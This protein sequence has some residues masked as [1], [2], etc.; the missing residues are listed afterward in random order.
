MFVDE[1][2]ITIAGGK[3]GDGM[4]HW[5][6]EKFVAKGGP[7]GGNGGRG[8][9]AYIEAVRNIRALER[10]TEGEVLCAGGGVQ[11]GGVLR[12]GRGGQ[13]IVVKVPVGSVV[14]NTYTLERFE[15]V[16]EGQRVLVA[17]G[18]KGGFGNA[19]FKSSVNTTPTV[20]TAGQEGQSYTFAIELHI[21]ADVGIIGFPNA[22]KSTLLNTLTNASARVA[23]YPFTTL[24]PNLGMFHVYTLADIPGLIENAS[25]GKGLGH[26][27]LRHIS[28]TK[29]LVH[30]ISAEEHDPLRAYQTI[31]DELSAYDQA[32]LKKKEIVVLSKVDM[33]SATVAEERLRMLPESALSLTVLDDESV[34]AFSKTL[35][36]ALTS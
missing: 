21:I 13:D 12:D 1:R 14:L 15:M 9:N 28:R 33:V 27:F 35:S 29:M 26:K 19:H 17:A 34:V 36:Q 23:A 22:G 5:R 6:R 32:L 2:T 31:R 24:E 20:A 11:G 16:E 25:E 3:G 18:G 30:L 4:V 10:Y 8:G 7:D